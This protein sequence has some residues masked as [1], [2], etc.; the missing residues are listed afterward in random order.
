MLNANTLK[1]KKRSCILL[2]DLAFYTE[3]SII[4][5]FTFPNRALR[6][7]QVV[8]DPRC[9]VFLRNLPVDAGL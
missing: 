1:G 7:R 9:P 5:Q 8:Y 6:L 3:V 2:H 4:P